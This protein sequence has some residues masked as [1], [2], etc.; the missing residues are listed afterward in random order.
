MII[1]FLYS[2]LL[3]RQSSD[4][5]VLEDTGI[6]PKAACDNAIGSQTLSSHLQ[7]RCGKNLLFVVLVE[8][9]TKSCW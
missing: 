3:H 8:L 6:E 5:A 9:I 4:P 7:Y 1:Y 2:T